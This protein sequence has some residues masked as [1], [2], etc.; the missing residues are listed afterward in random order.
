MLLFSL[1]CSL[2]IYKQRWIGVW[3]VYAEESHECIFFT[4]PSFVLHRFGDDGDEGI[5]CIW[6]ETKRINLLS[7]SLSL[8]PVYM[9]RD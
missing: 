8:L 7:L 3:L 9:P 2:L 4:L 6:R 5:W 1:P